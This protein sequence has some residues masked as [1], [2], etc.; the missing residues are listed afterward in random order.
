MSLA[1]S[2]MTL[3]AGTSARPRTMEDR[4]RHEILSV[5]HSNVF[6]NVAY[7]LD[8]GVVTL[9]GQVRRPVSKDYVEQAVK[10]VEGVTRVD[11]QIEVLPLSPFDDQIRIATLRTLERSAPLSRYFLGTNPSIRIVVKNGNVTLDGV[12]L[13][14]GDRQ[15]AH[16]AANQVSGVFSVANNLRIEK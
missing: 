4:V 9:S 6:D 16:M 11:N 5:P 14:S 7:S 8:S 15:I 2:G 3:M 10:Q 1:V 13:N 12:V